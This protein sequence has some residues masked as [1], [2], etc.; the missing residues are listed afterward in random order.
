[1]AYLVVDGMGCEYIFNSKPVRVNCGDD[2]DSR[3]WDSSEF[4]T[5]GKCPLSPGTI[6]LLIGRHLG[7]EDEPVDLDIE[8]EDKIK[9][10][11]IA[12]IRDSRKIEPRDLDVL[13]CY[14]PSFK[15]ACAESINVDTFL[16][17]ICQQ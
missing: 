7:Y 11:I 15:S 6:F 8:I 16:D 4:I 5:A 14:S 13:R 1:M 9:D 2:D 3:S 17:K 12:K 10:A